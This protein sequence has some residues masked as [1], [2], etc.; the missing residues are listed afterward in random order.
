MKKELDLIII[1]LDGTLADTKDDI[2][3][4]LNKTLIKHGLEQYEP[5]VVAGYVGTGITP[6]IKQR[7]SES[8]IKDF[9]MNFEANYL[10]HIADKTKLYAGWDEV[11]KKWKEKKFYILTN[12]IQKFTDVLFVAL[13]L[14]SI[15]VKAYGREAFVESKPSPVP[16]AAIIKETNAEPGRTIM[17]GDMPS[18]IISG[19]GAGALT[20]GVLFGYGSKEIVLGCNPDVVIS[21]PRE[22]LEY[23]K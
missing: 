4:A 18:D 2:T 15:F 10:E 23:F 14:E 12:K 7:V 17:I 22:L 13:K 5:D 9:M 11:F 16:V 19:R 8:E 20:C 6:L 3:W 1:D 21:H